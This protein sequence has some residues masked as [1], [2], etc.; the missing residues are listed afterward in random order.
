M[1]TLTL[2]LRCWICT[3]ISWGMAVFPLLPMP[4]PSVAR[5]CLPERRINASCRFYGFTTPPLCCVVIPMSEHV[6][7]SSLCPQSH[8]HP[9]LHHQQPHSQLPP[10]HS[11]PHAHPL[12]QSH[13]LS[14]LDSLPSDAA[15]GPQQQWDH[16]RFN[17]ASRD[18]VH[19]VLDPNSLQMAHLH[20][21]TP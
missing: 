2:V 4:S 19:T 13:P 6:K 12:P 7:G 8:P 14:L 21:A 10:P 5:F 11:K 16:E 3:G 1:L 18:S 17:P 20:D 15:P 9:S